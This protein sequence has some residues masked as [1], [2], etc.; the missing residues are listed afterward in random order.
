MTAADLLGALRHPKL[1]AAFG[2]GSV[3]ILVLTAV[4]TP[5]FL[6]RLPTNYL[7]RAPQSFA[8]RLLHGGA[9]QGLI[10][11]LRNVLALVILVLGVAML[12]LPGQG[13][14]TILVAVMVADF[15]GKLVVERRL[16]GRPKVLAAL[17]WLRE[18]TGQPPMLPP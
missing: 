13:L 7:R 9:S 12:I 1:L 2:V 15:P 18:K 10:I 16:L 6:S 17:N 8:D 3:L 11:A 14:I 5:W 4:L